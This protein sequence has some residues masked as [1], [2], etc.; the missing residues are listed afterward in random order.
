MRKDSKLIS[1]LA[2]R[3]MSFSMRFVNESSSRK[4]SDKLKEFGIKSGMTIVDYGCGPGRYILE[5]SRLV[6]PTGKVLAVDI[7][8]L[9]IKAVNKL[10]VKK[11]LSNVEA[12]L[13]KG[14]HCSIQD[15]SVDII[16]ALDMFHRVDDPRSFFAELKRICKPSGRL[17]LEDGHQK[18]EDTLKKINQSEQ[19][20]VVEKKEKYVICTPA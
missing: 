3:L 18:R 20:K 5:A 12:I 13:A 9:A 17:I 7:H 14:Y 11:N 16:Y 4:T 1:N 10:V 15:G 6:G 2:F 19:W 8:P